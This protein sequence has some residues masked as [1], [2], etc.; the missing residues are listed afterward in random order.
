[1][2][3]EKV[4]RLVVPAN[5]IPDG[6]EGLDAGPETQKAFAAA[7]EDAKTILWNGHLPGVV[8]VS[9]SG[10]RTAT[11]RDFRVI[12][13]ALQD[14]E[15]FRYQ[16]VGRLIEGDDIPGLRGAVEQFLVFISQH[17]LLNSYHSN[18]QRYVRL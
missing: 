4:P 7:I 15:A 13:A 11:G 3:P 10:Q 2:L 6:W 1:M 17:F 5:N 9:V 14:R 16:I 12:S 8:N 18:S